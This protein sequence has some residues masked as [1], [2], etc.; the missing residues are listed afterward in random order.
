MG[1]FQIPELEDPNHRIRDLVQR[2]II[3][4]NKQ[5]IN[6]SRWNDPKTLSELSKI[7]MIFFFLVDLEIFRFP[8]ALLF[9]RGSWLKWSTPLSDWSPTTGQSSASIMS[10]LSKISFCSKNLE[11]YNKQQ[12]KSKKGFM[13]KPNVSKPTFELKINSDHYSLQKY[14][15]KYCIHHKGLFSSPIKF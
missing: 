3:E 14:E 8:L 9:A 11:T 4:F 7:F 13:L 1:L 10:T 15:V 5:A 12:R 2:R 6:P